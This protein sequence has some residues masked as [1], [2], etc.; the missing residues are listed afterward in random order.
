MKL[1]RITLLTFLPILILGFITCD[2]SGDNGIISSW[3][4]TGPNGTNIA[5]VI[6]SKNQCPDIVLDGI[7]FPM[8]VRHSP[9]NDFPVFVCEFTL[10]SEISSASIAGRALELP[11]QNPKRLVILGDTGCR[12]ETGDPPQSCN[13]PGKWP[14]RQIA[15][16]ASSFDPD[17]II[18]V[19]DYLY[20][21]DA[22]PESDA[23]CKGSPFGDNFITWDADF[24]S[25]ADKLLRTSPWVFSRG[26]HEECSR[27]GKGWFTFFDPNPPFDECQVFTPPY[28]VDIGF[29]NLLML[30]S[31][32]AKDNSAPLDLADTYS[33][34][35]STLESASGDNAWMVTHHPFWGIGESSGEVFM[36]NDTLQAA[37]NNVLADEI[38]LVVSG[39]IH[40]FELIN[41]VQNRQPQLIIGMSGTEIDNPV[42]PP[43]PGMEI[44]GATVNEGFNFNNFGFALLELADGVWNMSIRGVKGDILLACEI[45]GSAATC[46]P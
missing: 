5:R 41:F 27:A 36:I 40:F 9:D 42:G 35:I 3:V 30:D 2:E 46:F 7:Q 33:T 15:D 44:A 32:A 23:G 31:S 43:F 19:G 10:P 13:D 14:F 34:Q 28:V 12:L 22:C 24:F 21:E 6:T 25:P 8:I 39:H 37:S 26:N 17:L 18:H 4:Q 16:T 45:D 29:V 20:R 1:R 11:I 38:S